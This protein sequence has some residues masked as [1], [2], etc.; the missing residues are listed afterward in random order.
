MFEQQMKPFLLCTTEKCST[1]ATTSKAISTKQ[2]NLLSRVRTG[3]SYQRLR[4]KRKHGVQINERKK[5]GSRSDTSNRETSRKAF[6]N[7]CPNLKSIT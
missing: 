5:A 1:I 4:S 2:C 3:R 7:N 6:A